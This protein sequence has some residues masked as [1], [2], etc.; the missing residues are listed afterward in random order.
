MTPVAQDGATVAA[1]NIE[2]HG[3]VAKL[4]HG[5]LIN[6]IDPVGGTVIV[7]VKDL[8][9]AINVDII[10][11]H[12]ALDHRQSPVTLVGKLQRLPFIAGLGHHRFSILARYAKPASVIRQR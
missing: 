2:V 1:A 9:G 10:F 6:I 8:H 5:D 3:V 7:L 11:L 12:G 4:L